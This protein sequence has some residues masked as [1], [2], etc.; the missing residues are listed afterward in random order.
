MDD[1]AHL[2]VADVKRLTKKEFLTF[3]GN[4]EPGSEVCTWKVVT[5]WKDYRTRKSAYGVVF[6]DKPNKSQSRLESKS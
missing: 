2:V 3:P 6:S 4:D 1:D 5:Y